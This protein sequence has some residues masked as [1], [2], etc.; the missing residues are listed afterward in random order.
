MGDFNIG[1]QAD[2][3]VG[4]PTHMPVKT[5]RRLGMASMW[6]TQVPL[7]E[8]WLATRASPSLIRPGVLASRK[9]SSATVRFDVRQ[10]RPLPL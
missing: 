5:F 3:R 10:L 4:S 6:A 8:A 2:K 1:Y 7:W 9:A